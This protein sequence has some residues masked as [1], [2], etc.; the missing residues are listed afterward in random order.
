MGT[1][2]I[3]SKVKTFLEDLKIK[4]ITSSPYH[5]SSNGQA[6]SSNNV[7]IQNLKKRLEAAK[8]KWPEELPGM[9]W[10]YR[11]MTKSRTGETPFSLVSSAEVLITI[12]GLVA[13]K[14]DGSEVKDGKIL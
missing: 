4:R 5:L 8:C 2:L 12:E 14:N 11:V 10:A 13:H 6:E 3:G 7:I 1:Q 9:L